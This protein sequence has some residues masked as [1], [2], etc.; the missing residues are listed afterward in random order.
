M[1]GGYN[2]KDAIAFS[3][4]LQFDFSNHQWVKVA[5]IR[6]DGKPVTFV[7]ASSVSLSSSYTLFVGGVNYEIFSSAL[8][9]IKKKQEAVASGNRELAE[10]LQQAGKEYMSQAPEW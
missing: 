8:Q 7:G 1:A 4:V 10:T 6:I 2:E 9:R 5:D 3:D